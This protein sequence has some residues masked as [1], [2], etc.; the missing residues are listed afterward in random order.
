MR[1]RSR[2]KTIIVLA[3]LLIGAYIFTFNLQSVQDVYHN[4]KG[5]DRAGFEPSRKPP[6]P[7]DH[8][9]RTLINDATAD[10][11]D[12][13]KVQSTTLEQ[14]VDEY[15]RRYGIPPPPGFGKWHAM[16][17]A[18]GVVLIDEFDTIND[19]IHPFWGLPPKV[20][21]KRVAEACGHDNGLIG[22]Q[23]RKGQIK[24]VEKVGRIWMREALHGMLDKYAYIL[25]DI[26]LA[27]NLN[28]EPKV[29]IQ[30]DDL[31]R[32]NNVARIAKAKLATAELS[33]KFSTAKDISE[34]GGFKDVQTTRF[35]VLPHQSTWTHARQSC[36][37]YS[38]SRS[39]DEVNLVID[40]ND[41]SLVEPLGFIYNLTAYS[42]IC[43]SPSFSQEYGFFA[44]A[45][46]FRF[47]QDLVPIFSQSKLSSFQDIIYPS[48]W[49][50]YDKVPLPEAD[51][52]RDWEARED[53][54]F[55]RGATTGGYSRFGNWRRQ[56]RQRFVAKI[57]GVDRVK[58]LKTS[59]DNSRNTEWLVT[60]EHTMG[61]FK[62]SF[63]VRFVEIGQA[64]AGDVVAQQEAFELAKHVEPQEAMKWKYLLDM[65]GNAFSGRFYSFLK[66]K[67]AVVKMA[68]SREWHYEWLKPWVHYIP[69]T[70]KGDEWIETQRWFFDGGEGGG[71]ATGEGKKIAERS[72]QW[73]G[74]VLRKV[75]MELWFFRLLLEY[76]RVVD[77]NRENLGFVVDKKA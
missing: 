24:H 43:N 71:R 9:I 75:D 49:Y 48:P 12:L 26:D 16:A 45:N 30:H 22:I 23:I 53:V 69:L 15:R 51:A 20:L 21:R 5:Y 62:D 52:E 44:G 61:D 56:H 73:S 42:D 14:A 28:D 13:R 59:Q 68:I 57:N 1:W 58:T 38:R 27:F 74:K 11:N 3:F 2:R 31:A 25:P 4:Q 67:S 34:G 37:I 33:V 36:P 18:A 72:R 64:D 17:K 40:E 66:S 63:N 77:D 55:W 7:G 19:L 65:D 39:L 32:L 29:V 8:P 76:A 46:Q 47:A 50:W 70:I 60:E 54:L 6:L 35:N 10:F 41:T